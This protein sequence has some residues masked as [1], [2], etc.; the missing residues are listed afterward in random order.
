MLTLA[1]GQILETRQIKSRL[2]G[3]FSSP[4]CIAD[5]IKIDFFCFHNGFYK[6]IEVGWQ[7]CNLTKQIFLF[8][9]KYI[10]V[11]SPITQ[12]NLPKLFR[13]QRTSTPFCNSFSPLFVT[14]EAIIHSSLD[15]LNNPLY[16]NMVDIPPC[17]AGINC[18]GRCPL[19]ILKT[20]EV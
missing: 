13:T 4:L 10:W 3:P 9:E 1:S 15:L 8:T 18:T 7:L 6:A 11:F 14:T 2:F 5:G 20:L 17:P 19:R 16:I 12:K